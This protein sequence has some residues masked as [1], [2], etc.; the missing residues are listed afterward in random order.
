MLA[1]PLVNS[2]ATEATDTYAEHVEG[3]CMNEH[4]IGGGVSE[5]TGHVGR[6]FRPNRSHWMDV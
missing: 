2:V 5:G 4:T 1:A 3:N 6:Y